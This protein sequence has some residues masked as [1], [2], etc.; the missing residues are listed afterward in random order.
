M[1][2]MQT[3]LVPSNAGVN[4]AHA[5]PTLLLIVIKTIVAHTNHLQPHGLSGTCTY[6]HASWY[7]SI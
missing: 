1:A 6:G 3:T 5:Q 4:A 2:Q 7:A